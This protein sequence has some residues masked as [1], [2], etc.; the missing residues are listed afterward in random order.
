MITLALAMM[1]S[2]VD[3]P[4]PLNGMP[5]N[6]A[7]FAFMQ[8]VKGITFVCIRDEPYIDKYHWEAIK[9][10]D[11]LYTPPDKCKDGQLYY[12]VK[13]GHTETCKGGKWIKEY[14]WRSSDPG[15]SLEL[16]K[17]EPYTDKMPK[18]KD[19]IIGFSELPNP[20]LSGAFAVTLT[21]KDGSKKAVVRLNQETGELVISVSGVPSVQIVQEAK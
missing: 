17:I 6:S 4:K 7:N 11:G 19:L 12:S 15:T 14:L 13:D 5:C 10:S 1:L 18:G 20:V 2:G 21:S 3:A 16:P 8:E 9:N